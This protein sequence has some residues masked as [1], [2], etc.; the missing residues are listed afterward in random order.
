[1]RRAIG[2]AQRGSRAL[3]GFEPFGRDVIRESIL[4]STRG[5]R[6]I[7]AAYE[8]QTCFGNSF[9]EILTSP[10]TEADRIS[11]T[12]AVQA[13]AAHLT[14]AEIVSTF[15]LAPADDVQ[16]AAVYLGAGFRRSG[17]L[18]KHIVVGGERK[19]AIV[20]SK[21]LVGGAEG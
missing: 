21:K 1:M 16:L 10:R 18:A 17:V 14:S 19:D 13:L 12:A 7:H 6:A 3:T 8:S 20:W 4:L 5:G 2:A 9:F 11:T 15:T